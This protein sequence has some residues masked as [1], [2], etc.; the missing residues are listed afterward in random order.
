MSPENFSAQN[1]VDQCLFMCSLCMHDLCL[2]GECSFAPGL[3][4]CGY[5]AG[6]LDC[7]SREIVVASIGVLVSVCLTGTEAS[8]PKNTAMSINNAILG[9]HRD[10]PR[11]I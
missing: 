2:S 1:I 5:G 6:F 4:D 9:S 3:V 7:L 11:I 10:R 8:Q